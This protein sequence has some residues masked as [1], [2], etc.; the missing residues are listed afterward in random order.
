MNLLQDEGLGGLAL[1]FSFC[2]ANMDEEKIPPPHSPLTTC[3][4]RSGSGVRRAGEL[5]SP[6][7]SGT[8]QLQHL[9]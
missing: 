7:T 2:A 3:G 4:R 1:P 8:H 9:G 6:L 5:A